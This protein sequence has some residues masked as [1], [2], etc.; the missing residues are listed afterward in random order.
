MTTDHHV[1]EPEGWREPK[2]RL[3]RLCVFVRPPAQVLRIELGPTD[4]ALMR[5]YAEHLATK[6][7]SP[8]SAI[9]CS[10]WKFHGAPLVFDAADTIVVVESQAAGWLRKM[11]EVADG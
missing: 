8:V 5:A 9:D 7:W 10:D 6:P 3:R 4:S 11:H 2:Q 1:A